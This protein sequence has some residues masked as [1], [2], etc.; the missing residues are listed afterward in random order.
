MQISGISSMPSISTMVPALT[1][2]RGSGPPTVPSLTPSALSASASSSAAVVPS[3][4]SSHAAPSAPASSHGSSQSLS[5]AG[6]LAAATLAAVY[7]T[8][9][10]GK[11]YS[12]S[13]EESGGEYVASVPNPPGASASGSSIQSAENNLTIVIDTLA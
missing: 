4:Q 8:T 6:S 3:V 11:S 5:A 13:M 7:S 9:V 12:G 1:P 2:Q 10:G